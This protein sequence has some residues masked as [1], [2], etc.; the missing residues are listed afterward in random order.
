MAVLEACR[1]LDTPQ[2]RA[3]AARI[4]AGPAY[5]DAPEEII[6]GRLQGD[7]EDGRGGRWQD[8][9]PMRF[10]DDGQVNFPWLSDGMWFLTQFKRWG[11][12]PDHPDYLAVA[13]RVNRTGL[14]REAAAELGIA[15]PDGDMRHSVLIDG[16]VWDGSKPS[17]YADGF[18]IAA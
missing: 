8:P 11:L 4:L 17:A 14:Y 15:L 3:E 6:A 1:D 10:H 2:G 18:D 13:R 5:V 12:L 16:R 7:Y 9:H